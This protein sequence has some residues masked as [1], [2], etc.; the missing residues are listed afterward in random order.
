MIVHIIPAGTFFTASPEIRIRYT[1][2]EQGLAQFVIDTYAKEDQIPKVDSKI[3]C[4]LRKACDDERDKHLAR[5]QGVQRMDA[6]LR[7]VREKAEL[8]LFQHGK[9]SP[10]P[11]A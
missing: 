9:V 8:D 2:D 5:L 6:F 4:F 1:E 11:R 10:L 7:R 3:D